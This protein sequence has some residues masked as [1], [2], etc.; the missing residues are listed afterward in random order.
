MHRG[1]RAHRVQ[2][3]GRRAQGAG[4]RVQGAGRR[5]QGTGRRAQGTGRRAQGAG[6]R[7]QGAGRRAQGAGRRA[8]AHQPVGLQVEAL[9]L[10]AARQLI[11]QVDECVVVRLELA[12]SRAPAEGGR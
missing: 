6:Y 9:E 8:Q 7:A 5:A 11:G 2:G 3:A 10:G 4:R 1:S 12:Q